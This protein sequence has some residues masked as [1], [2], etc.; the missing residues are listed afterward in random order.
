MLRALYFNTLLLN[1]VQWCDSKVKAV[2][3]KQNKNQR[4]LVSLKLRINFRH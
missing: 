2:S 1:G 3:F 4:I